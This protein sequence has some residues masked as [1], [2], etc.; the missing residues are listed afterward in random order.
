MFYNRLIEKYL[1]IH[2]SY[3]YSGKRDTN[4][5]GM[6]VALKGHRILPSGAIVVKEVTL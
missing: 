3:I 6:K 5:Y 2:K 4:K 1:V